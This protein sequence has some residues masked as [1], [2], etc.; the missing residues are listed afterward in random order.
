MSYEDNNSDLDDTLPVDFNRLKE[1]VLKT[2]DLC[3]GCEKGITA[4]NPNDKE[5][6]LYEA[7]SKGRTNI[8]QKKLFIEIADL[9]LKLFPDDP[10]SFTPAEV[11]RHFNFHIKDYFTELCK[12]SESLS[13]E[14]AAFESTILRAK[15]GEGFRQVPQNYKN[16]NDARKLNL[17]ILEKI[18]KLQK[19]NASTSIVKIGS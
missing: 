10:M 5:Q 11:Y 14:I 2:E 15:P 7:F 8:C 6:Q 1:I 17:F 3:F 9:K 19:E 16:L 12:Q 18:D 13:T 4:Y